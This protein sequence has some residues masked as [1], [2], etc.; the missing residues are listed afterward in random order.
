MIKRIF[1]F[2]VLIL[3]VVFSVGCSSSDPLVENFY[4]TDIWGDDA[5]FNTVTFSI[6]VQ[7]LASDITLVPRTDD[8]YQY[9]SCTVDRDV[10]LDTASASAGDIFVIRNINDF[11]SNDS[12]IVMQGVNPIEELYSG[13]SKSFI[14]DGSDWRGIDGG[15]HSGFVDSLGNL[16]LGNEAMAYD[17]GVAV[18]ERSDAVEHSAAVGYQ[19][20]A[21]VYATAIGYQAYGDN[22][23]TALGYGTDTNDQ[24]YSVAL[25]HSSETDRYGEVGRSID[26]S[27]Q[28]YARATEVGLECRTRN[29]N[30]EEM[31]CGG[32]DNHR[33]TIMEESAL[34]FSVKVVA[35]DNTADEVAYYIM[36][37][38]LIKRDGTNNTTLL[39]GVTT[40]VYEDD[41][42]WDCVIS[43]DDANE[44]LIITVT[45]DATNDVRWSAVVM[46]VE[47]I[48]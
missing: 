1:A 11:D 45:G 2:A 7:A 25:G 27:S 23:G 34:A 36:E 21:E 17:R 41:A 43:A 15:T 12:L 29:D 20:S 47:S 28:Q 18:G 13:T 35:R 3:A 44:A 4:V 5:S 14:F 16:A 40:T 8:M 38:G 6:N 39:F 10:T 19:A 33:L 30:P 22:Y 31:F 26:G 37:N 32:V 24:Y 46:G 48:F 42:T 9:L